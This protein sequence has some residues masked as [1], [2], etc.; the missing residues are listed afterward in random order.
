VANQRAPRRARTPQAVE[1]GFSAVFSFAVTNRSEDCERLTEI[2]DARTTL[3]ELCARANSE[4]G[5]EWT[6]SRRGGHGLAFVL[7][8]SQAR[9]A[10][11]GAAGSGLGWGGLEHALAI[12][13]DSGY[14]ASG[15]EALGDSVELRLAGG[16]GEEEA[17]ASLAPPTLAVFSDGQT[18]TAKVAY[19][20]LLR[21]DLL[22]MGRFRASP[23]VASL[24]SASSGT[25]CVFLDDL[26]LPLVCVP[27][28]LARALP[29]RGGQAVVGF[30]A[31]T[32]RAWQNHDVLTWSFCEGPTCS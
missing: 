14:G 15:G 23:R 25:L 6:R 1:T 10:A 11:L 18:H 9:S 5:V 12:A 2:N 29:L 22:T 24:Q 28:D 20:P 3:H 32:G 21:A 30:T 27:L 16:G 8:V 7:Q 13:F 31:S 19:F 17:A 4:A 26:A